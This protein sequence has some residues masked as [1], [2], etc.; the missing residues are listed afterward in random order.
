MTIF[1]KVPCQTCADHYRGLVA[2]TPAPEDDD[3]LFA[4]SVEMHNEVN[5]K[6]SK[7]RVTVTQARQF[8]TFVDF[9]C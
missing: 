1:N 7:P 9:L 6:V 8:Y 3:E 5:A 2:K 4:W